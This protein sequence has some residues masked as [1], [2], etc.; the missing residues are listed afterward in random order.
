M[1]SLW[2]RFTPD[3][4]ELVTKE[5]VRLFHL[6]DRKLDDDKRAFLMAEI[7]ALGVPCEHVLRG[8]RSLGGENLK[9]LKFANL[10]EAIRNQYKP[11]DVRVSCSECDGVGIVS[12]KKS[13]N[14][15]SYSCR[16]LAG[17]QYAGIP[18]YTGVTGS[19][20]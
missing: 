17:Q 10:A 9:S 3:E 12:V 2:K 20:Q 4:K 16:C 14:W 19:T 6:Q 18:K 7:E 8:L 1:T 15:F 5:L 13:G 11:K